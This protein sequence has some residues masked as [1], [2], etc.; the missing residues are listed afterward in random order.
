[1]AYGSSKPTMV[2]KKGY[3]RKMEQNQKLSKMVIKSYDTKNE[4]SPRSIE[5]LQKHSIRH[6]AKHIKEMVRK[7]TKFGYS[8]R[9]A[10]I[11]TMIKVG[12]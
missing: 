12:K 9:K 10:H 7:M 2:K 11:T 3:P 8:F 4:L 6:T 5:A 1:M